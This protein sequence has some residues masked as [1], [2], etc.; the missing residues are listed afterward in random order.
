MVVDDQ[1]RPLPPGH[2]GEIVVR[3]DF[4]MSGYYRN[5][6]LT[7]ARRCG[8][9]RRTGDVGPLDDDGYLT[10]V[11]RKTDMIITGGFNVY[12]AEVENAAME[13]PGEREC[14]VFGIPDAEWG[15][16]VAMA[17][18]LRDEAQLDAE[19]VRRSLRRRLGGVKTPKH[20]RIVKSLP[21]NEQR[22][23][24]QATHRRGLH[25]GIVTRR[26]RSSSAGCL[27][28]NRQSWPNRSRNEV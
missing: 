10:I 9:H 26:R 16:S 7:E 3:G 4:T 19:A 5:P 17:A 24:P 18:V 15:E 11:G 8:A 2:D 27:A 13:I 1:D 14:A 12:P 28:P 25:R 22:E 23:D 6:E 20:V 21:R